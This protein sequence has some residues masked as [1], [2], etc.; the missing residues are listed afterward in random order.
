MKPGLEIRESGF[1]KERF[2][3]PAARFLLLRIPNSES[4]IPVP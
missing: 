2:A 1:A 4:P 3:T